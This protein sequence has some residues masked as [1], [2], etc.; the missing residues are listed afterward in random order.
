MS[1]RSIVLGS[2]AAGLLSGCFVEDPPPMVMTTMGDASDGSTSSQATGDSMSSG[3]P[4]TDGSTTMVSMTSED[5]LTGVDDSTTNPTGVETGDACEMLCQD[6]ACGMVEG[7][8]SPC[9]ECGPMA[10]CAE[11]QTYCGLPVGFF[12]DFGDVALVYP[13]LQLGFRFQIFEPRVVRRLGVIAGGA[14]QDVRMALYDHDGTGP[15]NRIVQTGAVTLYAAGNNEFNVGATP[16]EPG[17]YWVMLHSSAM[18]PLARTFNGD[19][20]YE[21][22]LRQMVPFAEGFPDAMDDE[23]V[24]TDYRYNLYMVVE[25]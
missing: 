25:E 20:S 12:N 1:L 13:Q 16:L 15:A 5:T 10:S 11:D 14:G 7:C 2:V 19:N 4:T 21:L 18:T 8:E 22:A 9:A 23:M 24:V 17:D 3:A 6:V